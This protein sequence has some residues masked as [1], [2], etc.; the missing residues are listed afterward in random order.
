VTLKV[1][2]DGA[3]TQQ[4]VDRPGLTGCAPLTGGGITGFRSDSAKYEIDN[5]TVERLP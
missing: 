3:L 4:A 2:I 1:Y 5:F